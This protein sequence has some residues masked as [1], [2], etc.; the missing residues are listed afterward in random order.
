MQLK[1]FAF[2]F[3]SLTFSTISL[4]NDRI[5]ASHSN[6]LTLL[7]RYYLI[8]SQLLIQTGQFKDLKMYSL[9]KYLLLLSICRENSANEFQIL[10]SGR[11]NFH[12]CLIKLT[13]K[14]RHELMKML[15]NTICAKFTLERDSVW[16]EIPIER[17]TIHS[18]ILIV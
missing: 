9:S 10:C 18:E 12:Y 8:T 6:G 15:S 4:A 3:S 14:S 13:L 7:D 5:G 1:F 17:P 2:S 16:I 11:E